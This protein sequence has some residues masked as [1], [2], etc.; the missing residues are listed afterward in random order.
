MATAG[1]QLLGLHE[2]LDLADAATT[3][4]DVVSLDRNLVMAA[5]GMDLPFHRVNVGDRSKIEIL[6]PDEWRQAAEQRLPRRDIAGAGPRLDHGGAFPV[7]P[8]TLVVVE[9]GSGRH[10]DLRRSG[11]RAQT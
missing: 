1:D 4:L 11:I 7:L 3:E 6:A 5:I 10:R 2:E 8:G 9:R